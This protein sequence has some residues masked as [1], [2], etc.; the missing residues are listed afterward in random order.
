MERSEFEPWAEDIVLCSWARHLTSYHGPF[1]PSSAQLPNLQYNNKRSGGG[2]LLE[3]MGQQNPF[4]LT[5]TSICETITRNREK[6]RW[7]GK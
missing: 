6:K 4:C 5:G 3:Y 2:I 7:K 1:L